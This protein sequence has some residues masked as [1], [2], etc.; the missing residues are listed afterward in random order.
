MMIMKKTTKILAGIILLAV[1]LSAL[2][3]PAAA[4]P[5]VKCRITVNGRE[6]Q[7]NSE[8]FT[9]IFPLGDAALLL[10]MRN[11]FT[12]LGYS[13]D[14]DEKL[15]R[16]VFKANEDSSCGSFYVDL[17]TGQIVK[18]GE[19]IR[20]NG[21]SRVYLVNGSLYISVHEFENNFA[22]S[23][24]ADYSVTV[25][26]T[27]DKSAIHEHFVIQY[28]E[29][30]PIKGNL[31][32]LAVTVSEKSSG[33]PYTGDRFTKYNTG[34]WSAPPSKLTEGPRERWLWNRLDTL[35][36]YTGAGEQN[37]LTGNG[38]KRNAAAENGITMYAVAWELMDGIAAEINR[39]RKENGLT[40]LTVDHSMCFI[41]VGSGNPKVNSVFDNAV[42]NF[43]NDMFRHTL[44][45][46]SVIR[47]ENT[48]TVSPRSGEGGNSTQ[49]L[50][51]R[52]VDGWYGSPGHRKNMM[53]ASYTAVGV[54]V[55][56]SDTGATRH[57]YAVF[58]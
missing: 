44:T 25:D 34:E 24:L 11:L 6:E 7:W 58:K 19:E 51:S 9:A 26:F 54:L 39:V 23:F 38:G 49:T 40:E 15:S 55:V 8:P 12:S 32:F 28:R 43:E 33:R 30:F 53:G 10:P 14:F 29:S 50:A 16:S 42:H 13:V 41:S 46:R 18:E 47:A 3:T 2:M 5:S 36:F 1:A 27:A 21:I 56:I 35:R 17:K 48:G 22:K 45:G 20:K 31:S 4:N 52:V 37:E 57:A